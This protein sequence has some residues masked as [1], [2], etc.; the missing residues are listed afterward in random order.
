MDADAPRPEERGELGPPA[1]RPPTA[2]GV[3]TP[4]PPRRPGRH[5][6]FRLP[7]LGRYLRPLYFFGGGMLI[8]GIA[9]R[10]LS[11][12]LVLEELRRASRDIG[13][14]LIIFGALWMV[15]LLAIHSGAIDRVKMWRR[16]WWIRKRVRT[17]GPRSRPSA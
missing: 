10:V 12:L 6:L 17:I 4:E 11:A 9:L 15:W 1:R 7:R 8:G 13:T 3:Q 14:F 2:V 16:A 5:R